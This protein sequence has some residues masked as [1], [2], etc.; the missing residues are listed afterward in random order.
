MLKEQ[1]K[2]RS[3]VIVILADDMGSSGSGCLSG[4]T[5]TP[6]LDEIA[7]SGIRFTQFYNSPRCS[8]TRASL[9]TGLHPHQGGSTSSPVMTGPTAARVILPRPRTRL[10][11]C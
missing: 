9:L 3:D 7:R 10:R 6:V 11:S 2:H 8:P 1:T 5:D 4:D